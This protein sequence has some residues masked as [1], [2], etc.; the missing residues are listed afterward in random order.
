MWF[1]FSASRCIVHCT[2]Q[3]V[4]GKGNVR[5]NGVQQFARRLTDT[6]THT[7]YGIS[8]TCHPAEVTFPPLPQPKLVLN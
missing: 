7:P 6:G 4:I 3:N 5:T 1:I 8:V 2:L